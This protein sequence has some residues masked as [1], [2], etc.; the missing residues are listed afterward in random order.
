MLNVFFQPLTWLMII[1]DSVVLA[2]G[3]DRNTE[4]ATSKEVTSAV[5]PKAGTRASDKDLSI[6]AYRS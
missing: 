1:S 3:S 6:L 5:L 4:K 2:T